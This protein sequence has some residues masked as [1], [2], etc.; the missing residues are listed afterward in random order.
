M[1]KRTWLALLV[2]INVALLAG[3]VMATTSSSTALAQTTGL[4]QN[5]LAV[6]GEVQDQFD[7]LYLIDTQSKLLHAF[8]WDRGRRQLEYASSRNLKTDFRND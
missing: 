1:N 4:N 7:A 3:L 8:N 6:C 2:C 5:Y